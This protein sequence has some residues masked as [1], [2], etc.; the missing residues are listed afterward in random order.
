MKS[1]AIVHY[2]VRLLFG[3][4]VDKAHKVAVI[5]I[6]S[7]LSGLEEDLSSEPPVAIGYLLDNLRLLEVIF[8]ESGRVDVLFLLLW[9]LPLLRDI[10]QVSIPGVLAIVV[11]V[12]G[13]ELCF[14]SHQ[15][16][17]DACLFVEVELKLGEPRSLICGLVRLSSREIEVKIV[18]SAS[19]KEDLVAFLIGVDEMEA[20]VN[21]VAVN[22]DHLIGVLS[23]SS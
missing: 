6:S 17:H 14:S 10:Y 3:T 20:A 18:I 22:P 11:R 8:V 5:L 13:R 23:V 2:E 19:P 21:M 9:C 4:I 15:L 12:D 16:G 1:F 7:A